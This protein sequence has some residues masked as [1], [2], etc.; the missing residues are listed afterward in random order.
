MSNYFNILP[1]QHICQFAKSLQHWPYNLLS[2]FLKFMQYTFVTILLQKCNFATFFNVARKNANVAKNNICLSDWSRAP[3][4]RRVAAV[5]NRI[6]PMICEI[7]G[8]SVILLFPSR[9][10]AE[11]LSADHLIFNAATPKNIWKCCPGEALWDNFCSRH[12]LQI[13]PATSSL[14]IKVVSKDIIYAPR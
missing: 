2:I 14:K 1:L 10:F 4:R 3:R 13:Y 8:F 9:K 6:T 7:S 5:A 12:N 11:P